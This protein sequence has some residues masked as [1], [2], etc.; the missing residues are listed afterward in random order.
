MNH[1][2]DGGTRATRRGVALAGLALLLAAPAPAQQRADSAGVHVVRPGDTLWELAR[3][4]L[5]S[6]YRWPEI[7]RANPEV[8]RDPDLIFPRE[9]LRIPGLQGPGAAAAAQQAAPAAPAGEPVPAAPPERTVFYRPEAPQA[10]GPAFRARGAAAVP[11]VDPGEFYSAGFI[12]AETEV[13]ALGRVEELVSPTVVPIQIDG[14]IRPY[15]RAL[16]GVARPGEVRVGDRLHLI[17]PE[18]RIKPYGRVYQPT[19]MA[20]VE[21]VEGGTAT[22]RVE[23]LYDEVRV[24]DLALPVPA[25]TVPAGVEPRPATGLEGRILAFQDPQPVHSTHDIAF[26]DLGTA[27][28]LTEGD[29]L[30]VVIPAQQQ[31]WGVRPEVVAGR[32]R[33]VR[34]GE[35]I[36]A[37]RVVAQE[38]PALEPGLVVR[39]VARMP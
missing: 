24:G 35:R 15:D 6:P 10:V 21:A 4:Y 23:G 18:R 5:L 9:L 22:I 19:G 27:S 12:A 8:V 25:Y 11:V 38:Y 28:G 17:R 1:R 36:S 3:Q 33:I 13:P 26:V 37:G 30:L 29:E 2:H 31:S 14:Q 20:R 34:A 39:L 7:F 16:V 32:L